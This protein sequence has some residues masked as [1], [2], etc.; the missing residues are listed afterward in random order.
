[1][2]ATLFCNE[3]EN[4]IFIILSLW[5]SMQASGIDNYIPNV[6]FWRYRVISLIKMFILSKFHYIFFS[7][8]P[9]PFIFPSSPPPIFIVLV[10]WVGDWLVGWL[11]SSLLLYCYAITPWPKQVIEGF[12]WAYDFWG[13]EFMAV[14]WRQGSRQLEQLRAHILIY[15]P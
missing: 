5:W 2:L 15:K 1:M 11:A 13:L 4:H 7:L 8:P 10:G 3:L 9:R 12:I 14:D 6:F